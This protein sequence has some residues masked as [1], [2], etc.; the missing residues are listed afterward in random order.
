MIANKLF[1]VVTAVSFIQ[2]LGGQTIFNIS[3]TQP[4]LLQRLW[5]LSLFFTRFYCGQ[6][7]FTQT[8]LSKSVPRSTGERSHADVWENRLPFPSKP[9]NNF[10]GIDISQPTPSMS[11]S[12]P[13]FSLDKRHRLSISALTCLYPAVSGVRHSIFCIHT[14]K[15]SGR[16]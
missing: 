6:N 4:F 1:L 5:N 14:L 13:S 12:V 2:F 10:S 7:V 11:L 8:A 3:S 15:K 16:A 9:K